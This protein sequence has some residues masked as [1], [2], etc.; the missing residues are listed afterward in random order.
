MNENKC[1]RKKDE[2][3]LAE[4]SKLTSTLTSTTSATQTETQTYTAATNTTIK[5]YDDKND[6]EGVAIH[7]RVDDVSSAIDFGVEP[8]PKLEVAVALV[9]AKAKGPITAED[10]DDFDSDDEEN[11]LDNDEEND[12]DNDDFPND[13]EED[14]DQGGD[15]DKEG[16]HPVF[17]YTSS[18]TSASPSKKQKRMSNASSQMEISSRPSVNAANYEYPKGEQ[19]IPAS[20]DY[21][22]LQQARQRQQQFLSSQTAAAAAADTYHDY[23]RETSILSARRRGGSPTYDINSDS[24]PAAAAAELMHIDPKKFMGKEPPFPV[25]LHRILS[26]PAYSD[27]ISWLPH[28]RSWRVLKPKAFEEEIAPR[29][30]RHTK[31]ASFMRQVRVLLSLLDNDTIFYVYIIQYSLSFT[32]AH[33]YLL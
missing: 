32:L 6:N 9:K 19:K 33:C 27:L 12:L 30:F 5:V 8:K 23:S 21:G 18:S 22:Q 31:F 4:P 10:G 13:D 16:S 1:D 20:P 17:T 29:Y 14:D 7:G 2:A 28:G 11:D 24:N 26:N 3:N 25:K 15:Y